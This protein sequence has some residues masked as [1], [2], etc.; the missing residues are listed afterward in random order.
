MFL[1]SE[2]IVWIRWISILIFIFKFIS[3]FMFIQ[4]WIRMFIFIL[5]I[6]LLQPHSESWLAAALWMQL[7][8]KTLSADASQLVPN[9]KYKNSTNN[10]SFY[11][12]SWRIPPPQERDCSIVLY[13]FFEHKQNKMSSEYWTK[14]S[15]KDGLLVDVFRFLMFITCWANSKNKSKRALV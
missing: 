10:P 11:L 13:M 5:L 12:N 7:Q 2:L 15:V 14:W 8:V 6:R 9:S 4:L 1:D 3:I